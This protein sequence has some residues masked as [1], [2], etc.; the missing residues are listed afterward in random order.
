MEAIFG[1]G[2][3][4]LP[5]SSIARFDDELKEKLDDIRENGEYC[6]IRELYL[7]D[8]ALQSWE[9][10]SV[11]FV[12]AKING[13]ERS[14]SFEAYE[15]GNMLAA[16]ESDEEKW[17]N[18]VIIFPLSGEEFEK[19]SETENGYDVLIK[20]KEEIETYIPEEKLAEEDIELPKEV[21]VFVSNGE[22]TNK[23]TDKKKLEPYH[24]YILEGAELLAKRWF[25]TKEKQKEFKDK[26]IQDFQKTTFEINNNGEWIKLSEK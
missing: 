19:V 5:P 20:E 11:N 2:S 17:I 7:S 21:K 18:G 8:Q 15:Q 3:L 9:D 23:D 26:F 24:R 22:H 4:I 10:S 1:Y 13:V 6:D 16:E 12:P 25:Q 14:Y